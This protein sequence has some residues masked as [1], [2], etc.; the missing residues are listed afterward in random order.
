M[1]L[2]A[3][4]A[5]LVT[6]LVASLLVTSA[7]TARYSQSLTGAIPATE[8]TRATAADTGL[9]IFGIV[10]DEPKPAHE[11]VSG[12]IAGCKQLVRVQVDYRELVV[13]F[14]GIPRVEVTG[15]CVQ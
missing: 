4:R 8:G 15:Y 11:L 7:C 13:V 10:V 5:S 1:S 6:G 3:L 12:M 14:V 2:R 9:S